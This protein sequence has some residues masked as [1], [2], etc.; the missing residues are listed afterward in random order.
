MQASC[1]D[2]LKT[3]IAAELRAGN[4]ETVLDLIELYDFIVAD[5][6]DR[7]PELYFIEGN[8]YA[9]RNDSV[10]LKTAMHKIETLGRGEQLHEKLAVYLEKM[11]SYIPADKYLEGYWITDER[12]AQKW[13]DVK[14]ALSP[15]YLFKAEQV[16]DTTRLT[17]WK[18]LTA[19][20]Y[21][22][23]AAQM[24]HPQ[25]VIPY[26]V[27]SLYILWS[28][29]RLRNINP[30]RVA[31][32]RNIVRETSAQ[33]SGIF[34]QRHQY[35]SSERLGNQLMTNL[36]EMGINSLISS[37]STPK[38][39]ILLVE[40]RLKRINDRLYRGT[41]H[42]Y[43]CIASADG[44]KQE[45]NYTSPCNLYRWDKE[46]GILFGNHQMGKNYFFYGHDNEEQVAAKKD[47]DGYYMQSYRNYKNHGM[48][49]R[50]YYEYLEAF[51]TAQ[52]RQLEIYNQRLLDPAQTPIIEVPEGMQMV[53]WLGLGGQ[54]ATP[55]LV[56]EHKLAA[57][58]GVVVDSLY[59][60][61]PAL[62]AGIRKGDLVQRVNGKETTSLEAL[63]QMIAAFEPGAEITIDGE[64]AGKPIKRLVRLS[65]QFIPRKD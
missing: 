34:A 49:T 36:A 27:D 56:T 5:P 24:R 61:S 16:A 37:L 40:F 42:H 32:Y 10:A 48:V 39:T 55:E 15:Y 13:R 43:L 64:R 12:L 6:A 19:G 58:V 31:A 41:R 45:I 20:L 2:A 60:S 65:Y 59:A 25:L 29:E 28:S 4:K 21:G 26:A 53:G 38:K 17:L 14:Y 7:A 63:N 30:E 11:R 51:N 62:V 18:G 44:K 47:E 35:S 8:I 22:E 46:S 9:E 54:S 3:K 23:A 50:S 57:N 52:Y 1:R 33:A